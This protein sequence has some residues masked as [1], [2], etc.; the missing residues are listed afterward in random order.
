MSKGTKVYTLPEKEGSRF[1][2]KGG[3]LNFT[4]DNPYG[5]TEGDKRYWDDYNVS[6]DKSYSPLKLTFTKSGDEE[7]DTNRKNYAQAIV[8]N[9][10][11]LEEAANI[12][13]NR[14]ISGGKKYIKEHGTRNYN[15]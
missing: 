7:Y 8:S 4:A 11:T 9:K 5:E 15:K 14:G 10:R 3:K 6:I 1:I 12:Y 13:Y 2:I